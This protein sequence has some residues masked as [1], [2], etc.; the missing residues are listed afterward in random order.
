[1]DREK[2]RKGEAEGG[3]GEAGEESKR[4]EG[5]VTTGWR[6]TQEGQHFGRFLVP[7]SEF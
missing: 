7:I 2:G 4:I 6:R 3:A 5:G 1:M